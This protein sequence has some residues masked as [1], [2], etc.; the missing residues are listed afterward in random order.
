MTAP[1]PHLLY[2][3]GD[4]VD[5]LKY[6]NAETPHSPTGL[7][8]WADQCRIKHVRLSDGERVI[9]GSELI[10]LMQSDARPAPGTPQGRL[11]AGHGPPSRSSCPLRP[12]ALSIAS[13]AVPNGEAKAGTFQRTR[14]VRRTLAVSVLEWTEALCRVRLIGDL[15]APEL[16]PPLPAPPTIAQA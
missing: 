5:L 16:R 2:K 14:W 11:S 7:R 1:R 12:V 8:N 13:A 6:A 4:A 9:R 15:R 3:F 10:R